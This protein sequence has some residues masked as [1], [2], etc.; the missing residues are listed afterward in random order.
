MGKQPLAIEESLSP[1]ND[2]HA[3]PLLLR[4][5]HVKNIWELLRKKL[6]EDSS[7]LGNTVDHIASYLQIKCGSPLSNS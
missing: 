6:A 1:I 4:G 3:M 7:K 5:P 2:A